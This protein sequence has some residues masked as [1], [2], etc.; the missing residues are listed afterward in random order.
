M[1][2]L[3][4]QVKIADPNSSHNG[5]TKDILII[6]GVINKIDDAIN[7]EHATY[8]KENNVTITPGWVDIFTHACDPGYE[9][10]ETLETCAAAAAAGGFTTIFTLP[11]TNPFV[12]SKTQVEYIKQKTVALKINAI[13]LG[14]ISRKKEKAKI[15]LR[16]M[17]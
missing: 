12:D 16:C 11:D 5:S 4:Q 14:C 8:L 7:D 6:D 1:N 15:W 10:R 3:L 13:P 2:I 9:F 17:I